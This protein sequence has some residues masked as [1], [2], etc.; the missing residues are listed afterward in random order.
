MNN[1]S[2]VAISGGTSGIGRAVAEILLQEGANVAL[3]GRDQARLEPVSYTHLTL[4]T[5]YSV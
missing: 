2:T 5:I 3:S 1:H 4:P